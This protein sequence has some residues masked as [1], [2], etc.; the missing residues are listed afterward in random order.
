MK[1]V[2]QPQYS[3]LVP[4]SALVLVTIVRFY[5]S[6]PRVVYIELILNGIEGTI[7]IDERLLETPNVV[8]L[9]QVN[10]SASSSITRG[11]HK[12]QYRRT[13]GLNVGN[14]ENIH[15]RSG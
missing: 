11:R 2:L 1:T 13:A 8:W 9:Y 5:H 10:A 3:G 12:G 6:V 7:S 14:T 15:K 4:D